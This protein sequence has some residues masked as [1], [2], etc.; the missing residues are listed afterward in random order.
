MTEI[1]RKEKKLLKKLD[2]VS[3][4]VARLMNKDYEKSSNEKQFID[5]LLLLF[6]KIR[7]KVSES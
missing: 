2:I 6:Q 5:T 7:K 1:T 3:D 4:Y